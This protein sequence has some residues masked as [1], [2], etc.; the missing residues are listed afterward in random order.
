MHGPT[1]SIFA[2]WPEPGKAKTRLIPEFGE[3]GA[4]AIYSRLLAHTVGVARASGIP[5][6]LRVTGAHPDAFKSGLGEDLTVVDQG[7][8]D[9]SDKLARVEAPAIVIGSDCPGLTPQLLWAAHDTLAKEEMVIG[10]ARDGGYYLLGFNSDAGFAFKDMPW[11][12]ER[13]FEETVRRFVR[14][15]M[16]AAVLPE[17]SD[18]DTAADL[19]D[20]PD[21]LP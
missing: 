17:L 12:T 16:R 5:F 10:P 2:R 4:A 18:I 14:R 9:L 1:L 11:S 8:G 21:F 6:E 13:V 19:E 20:W 15:G 3:E 7:D